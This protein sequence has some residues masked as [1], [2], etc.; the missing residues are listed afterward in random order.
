M[1][2][3]HIR[4]ATSRE[5]T[6]HEATSREATAMSAL[7]TVTF[8]RRGRGRHTLSALYSRSNVSPWVSGRPTL[9]PLVPA[10]LKLGQGHPRSPGHKASHRPGQ[11]TSTAVP[12]A[13]PSQQ[14]RDRRRGALRHSEGDPNAVRGHVHRPHVRPFHITTLFHCEKPEAQ[15]GAVA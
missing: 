9:P 2:S 1:P 15:E 13:K 7:V 5:A 4:P 6:R 8:G 10:T 11:S 14:A 3:A 12:R